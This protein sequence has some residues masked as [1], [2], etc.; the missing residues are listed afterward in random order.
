MIIKEGYR[1]RKMTLCKNTNCEARDKCFRFV[2][3]PADYR[4]QVY[5]LFSDCKEPCAYFLD[6]KEAEKGIIDPLGIY[7]EL[8]KI[9]KGET[10]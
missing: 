2:A 3:R 9:V 5:G 1:V 7:P 10:E 8:L 6:Q 4:T